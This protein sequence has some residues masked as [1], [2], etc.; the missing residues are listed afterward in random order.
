MSL[1]EKLPSP[2]VSKTEASLGLQIQLVEKLLAV[3]QAKEDSLFVLWCT[4]QL[5]SLF[6]KLSKLEAGVV[7]FIIKV[8]ESKPNPS[9][10]LQDMV[11]SKFSPVTHSNS[12]MWKALFDK[13]RKLSQCDSS[14]FN[15]SI[16][17]QL[18]IQCLQ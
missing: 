2:E 12:K 3:G 17:G 10:A 4:G 8:A 9:E 13:L 5:E 15:Q 14:P 7:E 11:L 16:V 18:T 6:Q 1:G